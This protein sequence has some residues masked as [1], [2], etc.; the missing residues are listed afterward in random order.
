MDECSPAESDVEEME[1][2]RYK[3]ARQTE[4]IRLLLTMETKMTQP[5]QG[6]KGAGPLGVICHHI[7]PINNLQTWTLRRV[8]HCCYAAPPAVW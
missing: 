6:R 4:S 3:S 8:M 1:E 2:T 7:T 5:G